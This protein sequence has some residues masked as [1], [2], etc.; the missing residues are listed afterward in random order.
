MMKEVN[1]FI[2]S[3]NETSEC[4]TCDLGLKGTVTDGWVSEASS[5]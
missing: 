1:V 5:M 4:W 3:A 2:A